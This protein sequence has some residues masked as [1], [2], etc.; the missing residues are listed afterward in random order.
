LAREIRAW[1]GISKI[2]SAPRKLSEWIDLVESK[3]AYVS[4]TSGPS[5]THTFPL[6]EA[7][8]VALADDYAPQIIL[9]SGDSET[10]RT[11]SLVHEMVHLWIGAPGISNN[12]SEGKSESSTQ[13]TETYCNQVA[14]FILLPKELLA[15]LWDGREA[16]RDL[17][18][19][20]RHIAA[21]LGISREVV[22]RRA[23]DDGLIKTS[24]YVE[25]REEYN[26]EP[27]AKS[28]GGNYYRLALNRAGKAFTQRL[29]HQYYDGRVT[30]RVAS[31]LL[32]VKIQ[33]FRQV[34]DRAGMV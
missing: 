25:L 19:L 14:G 4:Q 12:L 33:H 28:G 20:V 32:N 18:N 1:L 15:N 24:Q 7:R 17:R 6:A 27:P 3:R 34:A 16:S 8:G 9:N 31:E 11:F 21:D 2:E 26:R 22:A 13:D 23:R 30:D 29:L 5:S 10:G